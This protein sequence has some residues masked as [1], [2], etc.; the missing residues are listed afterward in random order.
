VHGKQGPQLV[1]SWLLI[2]I[3]PKDRKLIAIVDHREGNV[4]HLRLVDP[5]DPAS[6][7]DRLASINVDLVR[8]GYAVVERKLRY[9]NLHPDVLKRLHE[10]SQ[11][12]KRE[13]AGIY[14]FGDVSPDDE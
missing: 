5:V 9:T 3:C 13:R 4:M 6:G 2:G 8:E 12:A 14:E 11:E 1:L 7:S 10:A